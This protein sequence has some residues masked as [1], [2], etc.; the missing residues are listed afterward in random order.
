MTIL[1]YSRYYGFG[2]A[3]STIFVI[4][5]LGTGIEMWRVIGCAI[6]AVFCGWASIE[7]M[8]S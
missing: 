1:T 6:C 3:I 5:G 7:L 8:D 2:A 4:C